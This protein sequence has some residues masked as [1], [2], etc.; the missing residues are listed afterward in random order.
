MQSRYHL[1]VTLRLVSFS[2]LLSAPSERRYL[3]SRLDVGRDISN[4]DSPNWV[5][6]PNL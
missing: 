5:F 6:D 4:A 1:D 2:V 3:L